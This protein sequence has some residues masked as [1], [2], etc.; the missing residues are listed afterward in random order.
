MSADTAFAPSPEVTAQDEA[1][2]DTSHGVHVDC[3][4]GAPF[5]ITA[6]GLA[7]SWGEK[8][9]SGTDSSRDCEQCLAARHCP[10]CGGAIRAT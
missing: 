6:C 4:V 5:V 2:D 8:G 3:Q 10:V 9:D 1:G 7:M